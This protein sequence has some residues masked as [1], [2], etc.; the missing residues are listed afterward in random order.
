MAYKHIGGLTVVPSADV[1]DE[2]SDLNLAYPSGINKRDGMFFLRDT[3]SAL[4]LFMSN[5]PLVNDTHTKV[6]DGAAA[7]VITPAA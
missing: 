6:G 1:I 3:G 5:G 7:V 2:A 4:E